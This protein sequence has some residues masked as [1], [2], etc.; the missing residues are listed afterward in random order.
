VTGRRIWLA[1]MTAGVAAVVV[2]SWALP[3]R[4][5]PIVREQAH[6]RGLDPYLVAAVIRVESGFRPHVRSRRGAVGLMQLMPSTAQWVSK[7]SG[8][9]G[10]LDEPAVNIAVGCWY[11]RYLIKRFHKL[12]LALAAY[13]SGPQSVDGWLADGQLGP[14]A[15]TARI[16]YPE[17][18][19]FVRRVLWFYRMYHV[20]YGLWPGG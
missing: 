16:P 7:Q 9:R 18:R 6:R 14:D 20:V 13:N 4:Y 11:L 1:V 10:R 15:D 19:E 5:A 12:R 2:L 17:T 8:I 3:F